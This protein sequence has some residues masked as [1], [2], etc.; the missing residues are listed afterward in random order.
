MK[1][2]LLIVVLMI[3]S[4]SMASE[5]VHPTCMITWTNVSAIFSGETKATGMIREN[6]KQK[7]YD[8]TYGGWSVRHNAAPGDIYSTVSTNF[9]ALGYDCYTRDR[10]FID[11]LFCRISFNLYYLDENGHRMQLAVI[12]EN[13]NDVAD[14]DANYNG[15]YDHLRQS[16]ARVPACRKN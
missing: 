4:Q 12:D 14:T 10:L 5:F 16:L 6:L 15:F 11:R 8:V 1:V 3:A 2:N 13:E 9:V 7:G